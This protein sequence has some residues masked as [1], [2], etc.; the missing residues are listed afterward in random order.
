MAEAT[1]TDGGMV[2][3][4]DERASAAGVAMLHAGGSATDAIVATSAVLAVTTQ[5]MCGMGGDL[6]ALVHRPGE[7]PACLNSSGRAGSGADPERL[8]TEGHR[9][10][11]FRGDLRTTPVPGCVDGWLALHD[12][13]GRLPIAEVLEPARRLAADGF[14]AAWHLAE[15]ARAVADVPNAGP[16]ASLATGDVIT[17]PGVARAL[18]AIA[19]GGRD[20]FYQGAFGQGL[21]ALGAGEYTPADFANPLATWVDAIG[22]RVWDHDVW[23]VP[24]NSQGYLTIGAAAILAELRPPAAEGEDLAHLM[25]EAMRH[26]AFD[27][28][29]RLHELADPD[30]LL[31]AE[32]LAARRRRIDPAKAATLADS[33]APGGTIYC[34]AVDGDG[35]GVSLI[36]SNASGFGVHVV[37]P[38]TGIFV[39]NRGIGF[40]LTPGHPAEYGPGRRP[41]STLSPA[42]V[43]TPDG[44]LRSVVGTMGGD[45]QPQIVLQLLVQMLLL[46]HS[47]AAA[48]ASP[49]WVLEP[50]ESNGFDTWIA[51]AR[52]GVV[53]EPRAGALADGL[54]RRGHQV[55]VRQTGTGHAH[56]IIIDDLGTRHGCAE[57][58]LDT[59]AALATDAGVE[60]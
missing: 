41:P 42:L 5:H 13:H 19:D 31:G 26:M 15:S 37:E 6:F 28:V 33:Y 20:A 23:T 1:A 44:R 8:R 45:A 29:D 54:R 3:S 51:P 60:A 18:T 38:H 32:T 30:E 2:C 35:S 58:R 52:S 43:T 25:I 39:H 10:M 50:P 56:A 36:Q 40:N 9:T 49:R 4:V 24:P 16:Y 59:A 46:G 55:D 34:C 14:G 7:A 53:L 48:L 57:P 17:R 27:R 21:L 22:V 47:P 11:P 12:A